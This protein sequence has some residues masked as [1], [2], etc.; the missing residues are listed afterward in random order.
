MKLYSAVED[1]GVHFRLLHEQDL[2]PV[3]QQM[4]NPQ[5]GEVVPFEETR[6]GYETDKGDIVM[7]DE[8]ELADL[9]PEPSR[10]KAS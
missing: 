10:D 4:V 8:E 7:L 2:V 5:T 6:R 1:R 9:E 3:K